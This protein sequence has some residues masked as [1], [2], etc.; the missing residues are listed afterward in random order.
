MNTESRVES[1]EPKQ[2][3]AHKKAE[4]DAIRRACAGDSA[5]W[6]RLYST[7]SRRVYGLCLRIAGN[8]AEAEDLTQEAFLQAFRKIQTFR[9]DST[10][11][12][13]LYRLTVNIALMRLR[14]KRHPEISIDATTDDGD[15]ETKPLAD[16]GGPDLRLNGVLD[17]VNLNKAID[18]LPHGYKEIFVLHDVQGY[19]HNEIARLLGC[20]IG[21]S[22]SQLFKARVRLRK[23]LQD[24]VRSHARD[25][26][27]HPQLAC[28]GSAH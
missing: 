20:S 13:W 26:R 11:S 2:L 27:M 17:R 3:D 21:N 23:L 12:T 1:R 4:A 10:F 6:E 22:K 8:Q 5:A 16:L 25:T 24:V 19:E 14:R 7:H 28:A 9:G 15:T 18:Q